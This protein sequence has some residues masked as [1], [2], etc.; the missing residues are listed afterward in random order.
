MANRDDILKVRMST[1]QPA[2]KT[3]TSAKSGSEHSDSISPKSSA[4]R[5][6]F[7]VAALNMSWQLAV[8]VLVPI[9]G[10]V[11]LGK[12]FG[13]P[14]AWTFGGLVVAFIASGA[15]M[16]RAMQAANKLPVPKLTDAERRAV[17]KSYEEEDEE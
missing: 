14:S 16:W 5:Q 10:G 8:V 11:E 13:N 9:I 12:K 2:L 6:Q 1:S 17:Q 15:V 7:L 4:P 3:P